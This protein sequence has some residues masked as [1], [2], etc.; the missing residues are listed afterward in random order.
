MECQ[1]VAYGERNGIHWELI[2]FIFG[3]FFFGFSVPR[4]IF[5]Y[6]M[7]RYLFCVYYSM[8]NSAASHML[9][10]EEA[11]DKLQFNGVD[12]TSPHPHKQIRRN[13]DDMSVLKIE[14]VRP[15]MARPARPKQFSC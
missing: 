6:L 7:R 2:D 9:C 8:P 10:I 15:R 1:I 12:W 3:G 14:N 5:T 13:F 4:N 11:P